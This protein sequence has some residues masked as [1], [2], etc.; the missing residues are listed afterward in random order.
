MARY[1]D[2]PGLG[3][4][5]EMR[6]IGTGGFKNGFDAPFGVDVGNFS[7]KGVETE[8][9]AVA[10]FLDGLATR[11]GKNLPYVIGKIA[12]GHRSFRRF[13]AKIGKRQGLPA[14]FREFRKQFGIRGSE[15]LFFRKPA[16]RGIA[17]ETEFV[18][19]EVGEK[20]SFPVLHDDVGNV[21]GFG[22]PEMHG[23]EPVEF[24]IG[25][26]DGVTVPIRVGFMDDERYRAV[27]TEKI[28]RSKFVRLGRKADIFGE[29][30]VESRFFRSETVKIPPAL[31]K[32]EV[33]SVVQTNEPMGI[34]KP[35]ET[36]GE[37]I[38]FDVRKGVPVGFG[39]R[40]ETRDFSLGKI[41]FHR[42]GKDVFL[43]EPMAGIA[44]DGGG[45]R[46]GMPTEFRTIER[47]LSKRK[48]EHGGTKQTGVRGFSRIIRELIGTGPRAN[49]KRI[50][51][52]ASK[53]FRPD[54]YV[55]RRKKLRR[56][57][58]STGLQGGNGGKTRLSIP[59]PR[60]HARF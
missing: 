10:I 3:I 9:R 60:R 41:E 55:P 33:G 2:F 36:Y 37:R 16:F 28:R 49:R 6:G 21:S 48:R 32:H 23:V 31:K 19:I 39:E 24:G 13:F 11:L 43:I 34:E 56:L 54:S 47:N 40:I 52:I 38:S 58:Q 1:V 57:R 42:H 51:K 29:D 35:V 5:F 17:R 15:N 30:R 8:R 12:D 50:R 44:G 45:E 14:S 4:D 22:V 18:V 53:R 20:V 7:R 59:K 25:T 46:L 27:G 26:I